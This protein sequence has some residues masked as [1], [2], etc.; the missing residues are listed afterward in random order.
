[1]D[2]KVRLTFYDCLNR[3]DSPWLLDSL[4][5]SEGIKSACTCIH[6]HTPTHNSNFLKEFQISQIKGDLWYHIFFP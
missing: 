5:V 3:E 1:M 6:T 2:A 4:F